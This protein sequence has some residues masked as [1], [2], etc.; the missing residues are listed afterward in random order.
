MNFVGDTEFY[1]DDD[2][3]YGGGES[4]VDGNESGY[5]SSQFGGGES[6]GSLD[7]H[8]MYGG[9]PNKMNN[10]FQTS[11]F[12][13]EF[14]IIEETITECLNENVEKSK[15]A[16][17]YQAFKTFVSRKLGEIN[18]SGVT[19][20]RTDIMKLAV[21]CYIFA[22]DVDVNQEDTIKMNKVDTVD[23]S[24]KIDKDS[25]NIYGITDENNGEDTSIEPILKKLNEQLNKNSSDGN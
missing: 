19:E 20:K 1:S 24:N 10:L 17:Q 8:L 11:L 23:F 12:E 2:T 16:E 15:R 3:F 25:I 7:D 13:T 18:N 9:T 5:E 14:D 4:H 6:I 21:M 22:H